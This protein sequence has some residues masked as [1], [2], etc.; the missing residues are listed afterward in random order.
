M[1]N[2]KNTPKSKDLYQ[3]TLDAINSK[4]KQDSLKRLK[5]KATSVSGSKELAVKAN[6]IGVRNEELN[7]NRRVWANATGMSRTIR[8]PITDVFYNG[9]YMPEVFALKGKKKLR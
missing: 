2:N 3:M 5:D 4:R 6:Q 8:R 9:D 7:Q 1:K